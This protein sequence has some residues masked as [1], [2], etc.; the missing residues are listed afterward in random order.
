MAQS[1]EPFTAE[2]MLKVA[3]LSVLD[4]SEDGARVAAAVRKLE[5]N[6][7][8]TIAASAIPTYVAPAHG[9]SA[10]SI[11]TQTGAVERPSSDLMNVRQAA[12]TRDGNRLALLTTVETR[13]ITCR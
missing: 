4:L 2:D 3:T 11:D 8:P 6:A 9:R 1:L 10:W 13:A 12:W 5:D 7:K